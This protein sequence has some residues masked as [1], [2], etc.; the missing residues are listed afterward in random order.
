[1][2]TRRFK[3]LSTGESHKV[4]LCQTLMAHPDLL[5][6]DES[7]NGLDVASCKQLSHRLAGL[8]D[9]A[10]TLIL[11]LN[12]FEDILDYIDRVVSW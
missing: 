8:A 4:L 3:Y 6:L 9:S 10:C 1:M 5:I 2:L 11:I 7:F 12:Q